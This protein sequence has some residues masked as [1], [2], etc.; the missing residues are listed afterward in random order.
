MGI[1][2]RLRAVPSAV[3]G[4]NEVSTLEMASAYGTLATGG[5]Y[6]PPVAVTQIRDRA[7]DIIYQAPHVRE[8]VLSPTV[9]SVATQILEK[10]VL[11]GTGYRA[12]IGR[13]AFGKT[14]TA[15][16]WRDAWFIGAVPQL[17]AGV[18]VGFPQG[19]IS[20]RAPRVRLSYVVGGT[21]PAE[22]WH[23]FMAKATAS[24]PV[25][26]FRTAEVSY[27]TVAVDVVNECIPTETTPRENIRYVRFI[28]GTEPTRPCPL[29]VG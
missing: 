3:L 8:R 22:I 27:V 17:V 2:S 13:P 1:T 9:A 28:E 6:A 26:D 12:N 20:M 19:Q 7:G 29:T 5:Y 16:E 14:G 15:Q 10:V 25:R 21:W 24:L 11:Y 18:W 4:T 23:A